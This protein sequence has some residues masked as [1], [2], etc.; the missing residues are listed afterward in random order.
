MRDEL[1]ATARDA[2]RAT[3]EVE[4][5]WRGRGKGEGMEAAKAEEMTWSRMNKAAKRR[6]GIL[7][8]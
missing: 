1:E 4:L 3:F 2:F 5:W 6:F 7:I 8:L